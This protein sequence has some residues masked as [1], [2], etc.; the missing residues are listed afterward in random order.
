MLFLL[1]LLCAR[2]L[3][4]GSPDWAWAFEILA[5]RQQLATLK[6]QIQRAQTRTSDRAFWAILSRL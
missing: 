2:L 3:S 1:R 6:R 4:G 5:L